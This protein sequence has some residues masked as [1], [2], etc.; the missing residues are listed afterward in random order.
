M[1][2]WF[3]V[4]APITSYTTSI[5]LGSNLRYQDK[6]IDY[7]ILIDYVR[8][9]IAEEFF[10]NNVKMEKN[11]IQF[12]YIEFNGAWVEIHL[13]VSS[14]E[15]YIMLSEATGYPDCSKNL[16]MGVFQHAESKF[17]I[18]FAPWPLQQYKLS[19][20]SCTSNSFVFGNDNNK[21]VHH[22]D[23]KRANYFYCC[24]PNKLSNLARFVGDWLSRQWNV[25]L[26]VIIT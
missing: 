21:L 8:D 3:W 26:K 10:R 25:L 6:E 20:Q 24:T 1:C 2:K 5:V 23:W 19:V 13:H 22:V 18:R 16:H 11:K 9:D 17:A 4:T 14:S 7:R 12:F 15:N